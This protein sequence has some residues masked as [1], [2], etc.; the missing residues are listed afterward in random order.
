M[1]SEEEENGLLIRM[2]ERPP[3]HVAS[4]QVQ[5]SRCR[6]HHSTRANRWRGGYELCGSRQKRAGLPTH[7]EPGNI[8]LF[9]SNAQKLPPP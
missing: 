5:A 1:E 9:K 2:Y 7:K 8:Q 6:H 4:S 3:M